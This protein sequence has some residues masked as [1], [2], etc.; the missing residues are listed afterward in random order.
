M[1]VSVLD[2]VDLSTGGGGGGGRQAG[3]G[4]EGS[5]VEQRRY[6]RSHLAEGEVARAVR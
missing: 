2:V 1:S 3:G 4:R 6:W 5:G